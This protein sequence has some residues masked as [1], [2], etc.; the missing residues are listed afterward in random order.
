MSRL[1]NVSA[2]AKPAGSRGSG[3]GGHHT[4]FF[5]ADLHAARREPTLV[6]DVE[7]MLGCRADDPITDVHVE[8]RRDTL[9][10]AEHPFA[11]K[12]AIGVV[13][14]ARQ[15]PIARVAELFVAAERLDRL[16]CRF[17][18]HQRRA[19]FEAGNGS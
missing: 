9:E 2:Q 6:R 1:W 12:R 5:P 19:G 15:N 3:F 7:R 4:Y 11:N 16:A 10:P 18:Q 14:V 13:F 8:K 17:V